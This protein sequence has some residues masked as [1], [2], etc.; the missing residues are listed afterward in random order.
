[1]RYLAAYLLA[2]LGGN[3]NPS[4]NDIASILQATGI[5]VNKDEAEK[6]VAELSGKNINQL[7][8]SGSAKLAS[9]PSG[10]A[11]PSAA[12]AGSAPVAAGAPGASSAK[13]E[14]KKPE[15]QEE[16]EGDIGLGLFD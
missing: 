7:M 3:E 14:E 4:S 8:S 13:D 5:A 6:T 2:N 1:M 11:A 12:R 10:G 15:P 9:M 16:E